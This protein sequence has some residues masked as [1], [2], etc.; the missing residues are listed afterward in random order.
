[1]TGLY[2]LRFGAIGERTLHVVVDMQRLFAEAG[3]WHTPA[4]MS[5]TPAISGIV[6][7]H[8]E[9]TVFTRFVTPHSANLTVGT[10]QRYY[11]HWQA[12]T[13][14]RMSR[15]KLDLIEPLKKFSPP[16]ATISK[17]THSA[18]ESPAFVQML[19]NRLPDTLIFTGVE[20]DV[21]VLASVLTAVDRGYRTIVVT[22]AVASSSAAAHRATLELVLPRFD[23]QIELVGSRELLSRW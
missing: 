19:L 10:W 12:V 11:Q 13:L 7:R 6:A 14:D 23:Q 17:T 8:P 5:I 9:Q 22:D 3:D 18:F 4:L 20:T 16:A 15:D 21:C 1:M 2:G